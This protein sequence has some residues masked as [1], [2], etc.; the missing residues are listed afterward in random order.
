MDINQLLLQNKFAVNELLRQ[1][2]IISN[3]MQTGIKKAYQEHGD[4][5]LL[6]LVNRLS[7]KSPLANYDPTTD[8]GPEAPDGSYVNTDGI[9]VVPTTSGGGSNF[10][11][12][13]GN[14][15]NYAGATATTI[16]AFKQNLSGVPATTDPAA[17]ST[18]GSGNLLYWG[19]GILVVE[20]GRAHV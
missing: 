14:V 13:W 20:I 3:D 16:G 9:T 6:K 2:N 12:L 5:F 8:M 15:L 11:D 4:K 7:G 1:H 17:S 19:A 10:W 18:S